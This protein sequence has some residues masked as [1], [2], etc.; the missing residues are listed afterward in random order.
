VAVCTMRG[1]PLIDGDSHRT[2]STVAEF[3]HLSERPLRDGWPDGTRD[4]RPWLVENLAYLSDSLG[5]ALS[6]VGLGVRSDHADMLGLE[7]GQGRLFL[8]ENQLEPATMSWLG[9]LLAV[10]AGTEAKAVLWIAERF[11]PD[12]LAALNWIN[13]NTFPDIEL[14]AIEIH[15]LQIGVSRLAPQFRVV[16]R[17]SDRVKHIRSETQAVRAWSGGGR[18]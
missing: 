7:D 12:H 14:Y 8:V 13:N 6:F 15:L 4:F 1:A 3:D 17:P 10:C 11:E 16:V 2:D 18:R 9:H 5:V